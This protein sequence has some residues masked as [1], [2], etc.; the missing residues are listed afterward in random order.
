MRPGCEIALVKIDVKECD[1]C[2]GMGGCDVPPVMGAFAGWCLDS[3]AMKAFVVGLVEVE[4]NLEAQWRIFDVLTLVLL[5]FGTRW[6]CL[7][8]I[9]VL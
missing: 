8:S 9:M 4:L 6:W 3:A 1:A 2:Y 5:L 7:S